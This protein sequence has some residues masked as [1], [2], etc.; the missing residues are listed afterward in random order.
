LTNFKQSLKN[1]NIKKIDNKL[2]INF[3]IYIFYQIE[4][5]ESEKVQFELKKKRAMKRNLRYKSKNQFK[6]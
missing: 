1:L 3:N 2:K 4:E 6:N 5:S